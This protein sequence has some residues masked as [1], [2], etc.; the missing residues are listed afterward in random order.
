MPAANPKCVFS[1][2]DFYDMGQRLIG[3]KD[4]NCYR[5]RMR[6][7]KVHFGIEPEYITITRALL[8]GSGYLDQLGPRSLNPEHMIWT[9]M[10]MNRYCTKHKKKMPLLASVMRRLF[11]L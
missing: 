3:F 5:V 8:A 2:K 4:T 1:Q 6:R 9:F 7:F 11:I 10:F